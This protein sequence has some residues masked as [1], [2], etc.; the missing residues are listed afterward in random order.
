MTNQQ[1]KITQK[2]ITSIMPTGTVY[3][4]RDSQL[5]GFAIKVTARGKA[6]YVA[7]TRIK[8]GSS[9]R[10][11]LGTVENERLD[12]AKTECR[13]IISLAKRGLDPR[14]TRE[15]KNPVHKTL[16]FHVQ[17]YFQHK[18]LRA[19]TIRTYRNQLRNAFSPWF[20]LPVSSISPDMISTK[21]VEMSASA[22]S[23][24]YIRACFRALSAIL[25]TADLPKNPIK[26]ANKKWGYSLQSTPPEEAQYLQGNGITK[27]V[28]AYLASEQ[29]IDKYI[30][31]HQTGDSIFLGSRPIPNIHAACLFLLL[32]G[33]RKQDAVSLKWTQ[34]DFD[35]GKITYPAK[36]RK[37]KRGHVVPITGMIKDVLSNLP[38]YGE[39]SE[40]VFGMT[41]SM[42]NSRYKASIKPLIGYS[43]KSLR[44]T[45][46]EH[47]GLEGFDAIAI[48]KGLNHSHATKGNVTTS[49]YFTGGLVNFRNLEQMYLELQTR[50][51]HYFAG[52]GIEEV[53]ADFAAN[54]VAI[55]NGHLIA[56]FPSLFQSIATERFEHLNEQ[57][58]DILMEV[59]NQQI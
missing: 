49:S 36:S 27:L 57:L 19:T 32:I 1:T 59:Q 16:E 29:T 52:G 28:Q 58:N 9:I 20:K 37:E 48:G 21:R 25:E 55:E 43:S 39:R 2:T 12:D 46:A 51:L 11:D 40:L 34:V 31:D 26:Q 38:R 42:F 14:Y 44:K 50:Y 41:E 33:G 6:S 18:K 13:R 35:S 47:C 56:A 4:V 8:G 15:N 24:N 7:E 30:V 17:Q 53:S 5:V 22:V 10:I 23:E 54:Y 45:F 3:Y